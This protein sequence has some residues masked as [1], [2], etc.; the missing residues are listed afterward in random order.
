MSKLNPAKKQSL[1]EYIR[2]TSEPKKKEYVA[3]S[4]RVTPAL[5]LRLEK[6]TYR[7]GGISQNEL[8]NKLLE[9]VCA[10]EGV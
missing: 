1:S 6:L 3:L 8:F 5:H 10:E 9:K 2:T 4:I 7:L